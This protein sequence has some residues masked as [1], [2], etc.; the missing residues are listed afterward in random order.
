MTEQRRNA[1]TTKEP[2]GPRGSSQLHM[3]PPYTERA[4][5]LV[6]IIVRLL[7]DECPPYALAKVRPL[8]PFL[9]DIHKY[10]CPR[11]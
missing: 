2:A 3:L 8:S 1:T 5:V 11:Y 4:D 7:L 6:H 9:R 10:M